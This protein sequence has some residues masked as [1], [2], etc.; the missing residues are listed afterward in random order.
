[1]T[2]LARNLISVLVASGIVATCVSKHT[3]PTPVTPKARAAPIDFSNLPPAA[4]KPAETAPELASIAGRVDELLARHTLD[5]KWVA[6]AKAIA[7]DLRLHSLESAYAAVLAKWRANPL[8]LRTVEAEIVRVDRETAE[9]APE[10]LKLAQQS[11]ADRLDR[12]LLD[13]HIEAEV[14]IK[15]KGSK[16]S[17]LEIQTGLAGRVFLD[18]IVNKGKMQETA[19]KAG[20]ARVQATNTISGNSWYI[21]LG[22][23]DTTVSSSRASIRSLWALD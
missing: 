11:Y 17:V 22:E 14:R 16:K 10:L 13:S 7:S 2:P 15:H 23:P 12:I 18:Q 9:A 4:P 3:A 19:L 21:D 5:Q 8:V 20:F 1:M 6:D